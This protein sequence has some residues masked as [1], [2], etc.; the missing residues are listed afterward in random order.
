MQVKVQ[1]GFSEEGEW[2][3]LVGGNGGTAI[4]PKVYRLP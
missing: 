1:Y 2:Q 3:G 4:K